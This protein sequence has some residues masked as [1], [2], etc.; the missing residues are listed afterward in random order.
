M[1]F[2]DLYTSHSF[3][4]E[5]TKRS[6]LHLLS[7]DHIIFSAGNIFQI[8]NLKT[9]EQIHVRSTSGG[10]IGAIAV[11]FEVETSCKCDIL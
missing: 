1:F 8:V 5:C 9:K 7:P 10:G 11:S 2:F 4:Y 6:N 3:G